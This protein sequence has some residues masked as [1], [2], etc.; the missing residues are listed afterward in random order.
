MRGGQESLAAGGYWLLT[1][2]E[3]LHG[4]RADAAEAMGVDG[5]VL[6]M[7][8]RLTAQNDPEVGRKAKGPQAPFTDAERA[9]LLAASRVLAL[10]QAELHAGV[11]LA[12]ITFD[13]LPAL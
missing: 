7:L 12:W 8:G 3:D 13:D 4:S 9:W 1:K 5:A 11:P 6:D 10:R 2:L